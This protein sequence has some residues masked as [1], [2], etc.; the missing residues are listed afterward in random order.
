MAHQIWE[1][2]FIKCPRCN[3]D[4]VMVSAYHFGLTYK[5]ECA[6]CSFGQITGDNSAMALARL[7]GNYLEA[8]Y[9]N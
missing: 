9:G 4:K 5:V 6:G 7:R 8:L 2:S 1:E 3:S